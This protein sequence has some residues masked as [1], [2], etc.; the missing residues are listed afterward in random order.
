MLEDET[1]E[2]IEINTF[3]VLCRPDPMSLSQNWQ[4]L[5]FAAEPVFMDNR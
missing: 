5:I 4:T 3:G 1:V 2:L